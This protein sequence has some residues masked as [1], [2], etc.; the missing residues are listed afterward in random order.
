MREGRRIFF[1][2][3]HI[4]ILIGFCLLSGIFFYYQQHVQFSFPK[5]TGLFYQE[6]VKKYEP[7]PL[8][9]AQQSMEEE[10]DNYDALGML[11]AVRYSKEYDRIRADYQSLYPNLIA[12]LESGKWTETD[13]ISLLSAYDYLSE[14]IAY[15]NGYEDYLNQIEQNADALQASSLFSQPGTF[16]YENILKTKKDYRV[17]DASYLSVHPILSA[18]AYLDASGFFALGGLIYLAFFCTFLFQERRNQM[19][20]SMYA[21]RNGRTILAQKRIAALAVGT[22]LFSFFTHLVR[23]GM[24]VFLYGGFDANALVQELS[25]Y[26][27]CPYPM[28]I[29]TCFLLQFFLRWLGLWILGIVMAGICAWCANQTLVFMGTAIGL[30]AEF[31]FFTGLSDS[32]SRIWIKYVN[33]CLLLYPET[34]F[35]N[36][37]NLPFFSIPVNLWIVFGIFFIVLMM[38]GTA[39]FVLGVTKKRPCVPFHP[40]EWISIRIRNC[41]PMKFRIAFPVFTELKKA[42]LWKKGIAVLFLYGFIAYSLIRPV[43]LYES[44]KESALNFYYSEME[45]AFESD[46]VNAYLAQ[47]QEWIDEGIYA[48]NEASE[49]L[50]NKEIGE[51]EYM[52]LVMP[53]KT[54]PGRIEGLKEFRNDMDYLQKQESNGKEAYVVNPFGYRWLLGTS[55]MWQKTLLTCLQFIAIG[56][57]QFLMVAYDKQSGTLELL[58]ASPKGRDIL[59]RRKKLA[60]SIPALFV[61]GTEWISLFLIVKRSNG[62]I[63]CLFAPLSNLSFLRGFPQW[64]SIGLFLVS[65]ILIHFIF[66]LLFTG[67]ISAF[68]RRF[69]KT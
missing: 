3:L 21:T 59:Y 60:G 53:W 38:L 1:H 42:L 67:F 18:N 11:L 12:Q 19:W 56:L 28:T 13:I 64:I 22:F 23:M 45:G 17:L 40:W 36:Y 35:A 30:A 54:L 14:Q 24:A 29:G 69:L 49:K 2:P 34:L 61:W 48:L 7:M 51:L 10:K 32:S 47:A 31:L 66:L 27:E 16:R 39:S 15:L 4:G 58:H 65:L 50:Q 6:I 62:G 8:I 5:Q 63:H 41:F 57:F 43:S 9:Q 26:Q 37:Q 44:E 33:V 25:A 55:S 68:W 52:R 20:E 46:R